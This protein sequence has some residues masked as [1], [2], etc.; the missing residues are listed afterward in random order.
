VTD[1]L[2]ASSTRW[3]TN[4]YEDDTPTRRDHGHH[5]NSRVADE[6]HRASFFWLPGGPHSAEGNEIKLIGDE[7]AE[8]SLDILFLAHVARTSDPKSLIRL[9]FF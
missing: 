9:S 6:L 3:V 1:N 7:S 8:L 2:H 5:L 4:F